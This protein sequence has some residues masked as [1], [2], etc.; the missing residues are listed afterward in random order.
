MGTW[1]KERLAYPIQCKEDWLP[2]S[3]QNP[4]NKCTSQLTTSTIWVTHWLLLLRVASTRA[5]WRLARYWSSPG[6]GR[7]Y[8]GFGRTISFFGKK[9]QCLSFWI[10]F[11]LP[12]WHCLSACLTH[13]IFFSS[14]THIC[15]WNWMCNA[16]HFHYLGL[17]IW[18]ENIILE[19]SRRSKMKDKHICQPARLPMSWNGC[20]FRSMYELSL[21]Y[22]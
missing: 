18:H 2:L 12:Q 4:E 16:G 1:S 5:I 22:M 8:P 6:F 20:F 13:C 11:F 15:T 3:T 7:D 17:N 14:L 19:V 21:V 9:Y 10:L